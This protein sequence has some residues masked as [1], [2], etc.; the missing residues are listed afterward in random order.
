MQPRFAS[1]ARPEHV[2]LVQIEGVENQCHSHEEHRLVD[3][4]SVGRERL[5]GRAR[6]ASGFGLVDLLWH[7]LVSRLESALV[8]VVNKVYIGDFLEETSWKSRSGAIGMAKVKF[9]KKTPAGTPGNFNYEYECTC[10]NGKVH[11]VTVTSGNDN[12]AKQL[13]QLQCEQD[14][15]E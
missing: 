1:I 8:S 10:S 14:C 13:A 3:R 15:G 4:V 5:L 6:C 11:K 7:W 2:V 12:E 9:V